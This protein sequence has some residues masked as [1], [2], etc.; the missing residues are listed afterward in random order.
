MEWGQEWEVVE[1]AM[2]SC[3]QQQ[4]QQMV[5]ELTIV[6]LRHVWY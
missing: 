1:E 5:V 6:E 4:Q 2:T 3:L